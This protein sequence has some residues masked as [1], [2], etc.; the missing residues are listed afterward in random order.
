MGASSKPQ[1]TVW[2]EIIP[3]TDSSLDV[4][5]DSVV[6]RMRRVADL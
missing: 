3:G 5:E 4:K 1:T 2:Q 6:R